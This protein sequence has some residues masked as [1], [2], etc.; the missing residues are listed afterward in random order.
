VEIG[1]WALAAQL[2][3]RINRRRH[4][5]ACPSHPRGSAEKWKRFAAILPH[6]PG[7]DGN[8]ALISPRLLGH[9]IGQA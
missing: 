1:F 6:K 7:L 2:N 9:Q 5:R 4:G 3:N 8:G